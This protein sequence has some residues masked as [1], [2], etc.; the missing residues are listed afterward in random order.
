MYKVT[1]MVVYTCTHSHAHLRAFTRP[2]CIKKNNL[3]VFALK[4]AMISLVDSPARSTR[5]R[6]VKNT[7]ILRAQ[8][9]HT[10]LTTPAPNYS[11]RKSQPLKRLLSV[12][13]RQ[14]K[15]STAP[16]FVVQGDSIR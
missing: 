7:P 14:K 9:S 2:T 1:G 15:G 10:I 13:V 3:K 8:S 12:N 6:T 5:K 4:C 11:Q 16:G